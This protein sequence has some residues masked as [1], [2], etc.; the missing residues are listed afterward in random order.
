MSINIEKEYPFSNR[1]IWLDL[2]SNLWSLF[3]N[4]SIKQMYVMRGSHIVYLKDIDSYDNFVK[5]V[6]LDR[7]TDIGIKPTDR[8]RYTVL[9]GHDY[10]SCYIKDEVFII[11]RKNDKPIKIPILQWSNYVI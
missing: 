5:L 4:G 9:Y 8:Y 7:H 3:I 10:D 2:T 1:Q 11:N 6:L